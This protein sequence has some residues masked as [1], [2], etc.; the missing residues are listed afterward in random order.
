MSL[1]HDGC[2]LLVLPLLLSPGGLDGVVMRRGC[3]WAVAS[4]NFH[5]ARFQPTC[6]HVA[7]FSGE[8]AAQ[9]AESSTDPLDER[10][11]ETLKGGTWLLIPHAMD[12]EHAD[13]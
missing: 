2:E 9:M 4:R 11:A 3:V 13:I 5:I 1:C 8:S 7:S 10:N 12:D 6:G